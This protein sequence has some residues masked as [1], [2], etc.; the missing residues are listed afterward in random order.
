MLKSKLNNKKLIVGSYVCL[1]L[2]L[3]LFHSFIGMYF[4][5]Y[6][7]ASLSYGY[8]ADV[9]GM[10]WTLEDLGQWAHWIYFNF[11]GR[12]MCGSILNL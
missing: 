12:I 2:F 10:N 1:F 9:L 5:D 7:N 3:E 11:S 6:G 8:H 4:D